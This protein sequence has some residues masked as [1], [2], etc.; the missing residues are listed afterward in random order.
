MFRLFQAGLIAG[1]VQASIVV[2]VTMMVVISS[3]YDPDPTTMY[4]GWPGEASPASATGFL[5]WLELLIA[6]G[7]AFT[8]SRFLDATASRL[9]LASRHMHPAEPDRAVKALLGQLLI[10]TVGFTIV[11]LRTPPVVLVELAHRLECPAAAAV[12]W[13]GMMSIGT[14]AFGA[15]AH[16]AA[17]AL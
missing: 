10:V 15:N 8:G 11:A 1:C 5:T 9:R 16:A 7:L 17:K 4:I 14:A 3:R 2:A 13:S 12:V 6:L